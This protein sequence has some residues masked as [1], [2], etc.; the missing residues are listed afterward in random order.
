MANE[1]T[2]PGCNEAAKTESESCDTTM[3]FMDTETISF[4]PI[5]ISWIWSMSSWQPGHALE[6]RERWEFW[7]YVVQNLTPFYELRPI[8]T[9]PTCPFKPF[10]WARRETIVWKFLSLT[11]EIAHANNDL[12][13]VIT[14]LPIAGSHVY[15]LPEQT[16]AISNAS[17]DTQ[18][19]KCRE[20]SG[21]FYTKHNL[22]Y[23]YE[24]QFL[25]W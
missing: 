10:I 19:R 13:Q 17:K 15:D 18:R 23:L 24:T 11:S 4:I 22:C 1:C 12:G 2:Y 16:A 14:I 5:I 3:K 7:K 21:L 8:I 25:L 20:G 9:S 6:S